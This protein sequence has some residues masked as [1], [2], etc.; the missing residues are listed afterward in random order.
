MRRTKR[1]G[2]GLGSWLVV[3]VCGLVPV[4]ACGG[5]G[6]ATTAPQSAGAVSACGSKGGPRLGLPL[7]CGLAV[8]AEP[9][10]RAGD[11]LTRGAVPE[12]RYLRSERPAARAVRQR[13]RPEQEVLDAG[14]E[15]LRQAPSWRLPGVNARAVRPSRAR[16]PAPGPAAFRR[17]GWSPHPAPAKAARGRAQARSSRR[18]D[19]A[20]STS[21]R[22][23]VKPAEFIGVRRLACSNARLP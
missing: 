5:G 13:L 23:L 15:H 14:G 4:S 6:V 19:R 1:G 2:L 12:F 20:R 18:A 7:A 10:L 3:F 17:V 9:Q 8:D 11:R 22:P 16:R 21:L